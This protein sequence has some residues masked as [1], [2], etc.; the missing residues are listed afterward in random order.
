MVL[1]L[2]G[3]L[4]LKRRGEAEIAPIR[5]TAGGRNVTYSPDGQWI[6]YALGRELYKRPLDG[7]PA[8][9]LADEVEAAPSRVGLAWLDDGTILYEQ[10][11]GGVRLVRIPEDGGAPTVVFDPDGTLI[12]WVHG[13]PGARGALVVTTDNALHLVDLEGLSSEVLI[14]D[15]V[16][17]W[18]VPTGHLVYVR[19]DGAVLA[20]PFDLDRLRVEGSAAPLFDGVRTRASTA[21]MQISPDG[22]VLFVRGASGGGVDADP[23]RLVRVDRQGRETPIPADAEYYLYP[24]VSPDGTRL[25]TLFRG[26][27]GGTPTLDLWLLDL[28]RGSR[29][30]MTFDNSSRFQIAWTPGGDR[31]TYADGSTAS[32]SNT[33]W[34]VATDGSGAREPVVEA[35]GVKAPAGWSSDGRALVYYTLDTRTLH[36]IWLAPSGG[37][38]RPIVAGPFEE[39]APTVSPDGRWLA[40]VSDESGRDEVYLQAFPGPGAREVVS[41]S[42]GREPV[43]SR[44]GREL[45]FRTADSLMVAAVDSREPLS[46][47]TPRALFADGYARDGNQFSLGAPAYD[48]MPD[49]RSFIMVSP[50]YDY[51]SAVADPEPEVVLI[52]DF[53]SELERL[54]P[55]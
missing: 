9:R 35:G 25:A 19:L 41:R 53:L 52:Q 48:V 26:V 28:E 13:L 44:D 34:T 8:V 4:G 42:G 31:L 22:T 23:R 11:G 43:W 14:E 47:G 50:D 20:V 32:V 40:Y 15:A 10:T 1:P 55:R 12:W 7:G 5:G 33:I 38:P 51:A 49:G 17:A 24:R 6:A 2:E 21:D 27:E 36:D 46:I 29:S 3:Q 16:R 39:R 37:E 30:R 54:A 45:F 18:Y